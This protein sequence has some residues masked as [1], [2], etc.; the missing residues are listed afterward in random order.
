M[1]WIPGLTANA[2]LPP[3]IQHLLNLGGTLL[4]FALG[5]VGRFVGLGPTWPD[6]SVVKIRKIRAA[7]GQA[8]F[9]LS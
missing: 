4:V 9:T 5:L 7:P 8:H 2:V 6:Q 3:R 1:V